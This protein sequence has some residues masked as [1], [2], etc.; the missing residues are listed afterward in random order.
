VA[1]QVSMASEK[2]VEGFIF[3]PANFLKQPASFRRVWI[4]L[5]HGFSNLPTCNAFMYVT[6]KSLPRQGIRL[7]EKD[8]NERGMNE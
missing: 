2:L 8:R 4:Y 5:G 1:Q 3:A 7:L 6:G